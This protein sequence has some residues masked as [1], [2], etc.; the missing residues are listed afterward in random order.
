MEPF[1][2]TSSFCTLLQDTIDKLL[3]LVRVCAAVQSSTSSTCMIMTGVSPSLLHQVCA[4]G[5]HSREVQAA[6]GMGLTTAVSV[7]LAGCVP[8]AEGSVSTEGLVSVLIS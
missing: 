4:V 2:P 1:P 3:Q 6:L 8:G 5:A 7:L